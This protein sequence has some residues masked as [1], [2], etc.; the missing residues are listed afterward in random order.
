MCYANQPK[1]LAVFVKLAV[2]SLIVAPDAT[3][4]FVYITNGFRFGVSAG[5]RLDNRPL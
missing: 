5:F 2:Q 3:L 4:G 1:R